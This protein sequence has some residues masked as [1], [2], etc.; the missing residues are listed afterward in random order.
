MN[1]NDYMDIIRERYEPIIK[2]ELIDRGS[3]ITDKD[4]ESLVKFCNRIYS[5]QKRRSGQPNFKVHKTRMFGERRDF[6]DFCDGAER[7]GFRKDFETFSLELEDN[8]KTVYICFFF[9]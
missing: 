6:D 4:F 9:K 7:S 3:L 2:E 8:S 1:N 5:R